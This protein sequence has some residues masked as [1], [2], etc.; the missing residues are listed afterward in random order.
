MIA[1]A[2][3]KNSKVRITEFY[4]SR[5]RLEQDGLEALAKVFSAQKS[6]VKIEVFQNGSKEGLKHLLLSLVDCKD[7]LKSINIEDNKSINKAVDE[8]ARAIKECSNLEVL[9]ISDLTM[10]K[11]NCRVIQ[12]AIIDALKSGSNLKEIIWNQDLSCSTS[13]AAEFLD[14]L[15]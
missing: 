3:A 1:E 2:L 12:K 10:T 11:T 7:T 9:N 8:L 14:S 15:S 13:T 6:L 5:D 4:A